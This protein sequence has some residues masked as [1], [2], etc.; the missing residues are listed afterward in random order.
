MPQRTLKIRNKLGLH[1]RPA[2][3]FAAEA[4][5]YES[6]IFISKDEIE[7]NGKSP[8]GI[9]MLAAGEGSSITIRAEGNDAEDALDALEKLVVCRKFDEE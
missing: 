8:V 5:Q 6:Q 4:G 9:M 3:L 1:L 7:V 2:S